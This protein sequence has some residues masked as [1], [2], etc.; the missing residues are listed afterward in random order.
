MSTIV[1]NSLNYV[2]QGVINGL[3]HFWERSA[4]IVNGFRHLQNSIGL[5]QDKTHVKWKLTVPYLVEEDS[6][7]ACTG[8]KQYED[9]LVDIVV[10]FDKKLP[11]AH[12]DATQTS[13]ENLVVTQQFRDSVKL[14]LQAS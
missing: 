1:L 11:A 10:R 5:S 2:G 12:R 7:C 9:T 8:A 4:G 6:S 13:I 3:S 14:L